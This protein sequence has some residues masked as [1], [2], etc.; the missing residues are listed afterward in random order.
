MT[1]QTASAVSLDAFAARVGCHFTTA[2]RLKAGE[3]FPGRVVLGKIV[4]E[5]NLDPIQV[6]KLYTAEGEEA[7]KAFGEYLKSVVFNEDGQ[8]VAGV[9][10]DAA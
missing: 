10:L 9:D 4:R 5:Y 1:N 3:R 7:R 2:S 6:L 8:E